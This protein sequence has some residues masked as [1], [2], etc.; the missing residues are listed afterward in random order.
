[1]EKEFYYLDE[2]EP[3]GPFTI[4]QLKSFGLKPDSLVWTDGF[5]NWKH[6]KD[7]EELKFIL[8]KTPPPPPIIDISPS[9]KIE[10]VN[11]KQEDNKILVEDSNVKFWVKFKIFAFSLFLLGFAALG[12]FIFSNSKVKKHKEEINSRI[13]KVFDG[14]TV[15]LDGTFLLPQGTIEETSYSSKSNNREDDPYASPSKPWWERD[16]LYTIFKVSSGGFTIKKLTKRYP[17]GFDI[18]TITSGDMGYKK[19]TRSFIPPEYM[20]TG[21]GER[22]RISGGRYVTNYRLPIRQCYI[23]VYEYFTKYDLHS[24]GAYTPGKYNDILNF[25][26]IRN[27]YFYMDNTEPKIHQLTS[28]NYSY[29]YSPDDHSKNI[30]SEDWAVYYS[31]TGR[32]YVLTPNKKA[33]NEDLFTYLVASV[34][35]VLILLIISA[36][37][38]P[39]YFRNLSLYGKRWKN[40]AN[41]EQIFLFEHSFFGKHTFTE[42]V[43]DKV[44]KG[45]LKI[46]DKGNTINLSYPN[47][48]LFYKVGN[49][50]QDNLTLVS[51][52]EKADIHFTRVGSEEIQST[53]NKEGEQ[54]K[55]S[56]EIEKTS[57]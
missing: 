10:D 40:I 46:T 23:M 27:E 4:D 20:D 38:K 5:E 15:V 1:M 24:P 25:N 21:W 26:S 13:D 19:P 45:V 11:E 32:H 18:E 7:V 49:L 33:I 44:Y 37:S 28:H 12:A 9:S 36:L 6:A 16:K 52:K 48:E 2:K 35:P 55:K 29:W 43:N 56:P 30:N 53:E 57:L 14:K 31:I 8:K 54:E 47:M 34:G 41:S 39:K 51:M 17:D 22:W 42:I 50:H 3:R